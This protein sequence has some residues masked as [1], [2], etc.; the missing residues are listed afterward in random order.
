VKLLII[1]INNIVN[2]T[3][4]KYANILFRRSKKRFMVGFGSVLMDINVIL[5]MLCQKIM[6]LRKIK[7]K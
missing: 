3:Q 1:T 5:G 2:L 7:N 4:K 6:F